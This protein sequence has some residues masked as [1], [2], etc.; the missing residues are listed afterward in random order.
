MAPLGQALRHEDNPR[1]QGELDLDTL[2]W[3]PGGAFLVSV[4]EGR[5]KCPRCGSRRVVLLFDLPISP[6]AKRA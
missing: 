6:V 1:V 2:V 5:F 4:L 3:A